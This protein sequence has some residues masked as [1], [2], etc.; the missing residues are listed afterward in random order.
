MLNLIIKHKTNAINR[1][2]ILI[3]IKLYTLNR[4]LKGYDGTL[5]VT[6]SQIGELLT[7]VWSTASWTN[8]VV[9]MMAVH[10]NKACFTQEMVT[11]T[12]AHFC[13]R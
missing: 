8:G 13:S 5:L 3:D 12:Q 2:F 10:S 9:A 6:I 4:G 11:T 7:V 1:P